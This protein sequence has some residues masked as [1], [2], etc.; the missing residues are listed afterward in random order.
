ME[1]LYEIRYIREDGSFGAYCG[2]SK[3]AYEKELA[4]CN[5]KN[6]IYTTNVKRKEE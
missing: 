6:Y 3:I 5:K 2:D 4:F 1:L